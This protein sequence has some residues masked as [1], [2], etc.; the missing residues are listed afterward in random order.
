MKKLN[1]LS[2]GQAQRLCFLRA[3]L[4]A[5]SLLLLDEPFSALDSFD[6]IRFRDRVFRYVETLGIVTILV[7]HDLERAIDL[8]D[9]IA[10]L[11][12]TER[13]SEIV[14]TQADLEAVRDYYLTAGILTVPIDLSNSQYRLTDK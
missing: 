11:K 7:T 9:R 1:Q 13:G 12:R 8:A 6:G 4:P 14:V 3:I 2:G 5:P 10:I